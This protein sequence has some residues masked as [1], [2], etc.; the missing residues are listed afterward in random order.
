MPSGIGKNSRQEK[1]GG[2]RR[3]WRHR[4]Y[5]IRGFN[6]SAGMNWRRR[7]F[8]RFRRSPV[9]PGRRHFFFPSRART[10]LTSGCP[11]GPRGTFL[12]P[13]LYHSLIIPLPPPP[14]RPLLSLSLSLSF[15]ARSYLEIASVCLPRAR[16]FRSKIRYPCTLY[17]CTFLT[18]S[19]LESIESASA[20]SERENACRLRLTLV[21]G[22][23]GDTLFRNCRSSIPI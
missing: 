6:I 5:R 19:A 13:L 9:T 20:N 15:S 23:I 22:R 16:G 21:D 10:S 2:K 7:H 11:L 4:R 1:Y 14:P 3:T 18:S 8:S 12:F 17:S